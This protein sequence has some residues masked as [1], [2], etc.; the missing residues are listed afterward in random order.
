LCEFEDAHRCS[1]LIWR[2]EVVIA[3]WTCFLSR[4]AV[5]DSIKY[6]LHHDH[7]VTMNI[8]SYKSFPV[9]TEFQGMRITV[10]A[11]FEWI[12]ELAVSGQTG[13][14]LANLLDYVR[15]GAKTQGTDSLTERQIRYSLEKL[16][17]KGFI[18]RS[19]AQEKVRETLYE[20][21]EKAYSLLLDGLRARMQD[22]MS[23]ER[24]R[25]LLLR[26]EVW[27]FATRS[28]IYSNEEWTMDY[29]VLCSDAAS[30]KEQLALS[31]R[32]VLCS[33]CWYP[34]S[35]FK[36]IGVLF[37]DS[38]RVD[39]ASTNQFIDY[40]FLWKDPELLSSL[41][42][43]VCSILDTARNG[44]DLCGM[45]G[46]WISYDGRFNLRQNTIPLATLVAN[47]LSKPLKF[48]DFAATRTRLKELGGR[49]W[50]LI[51]DFLDDISYMR[52]VLDQL[53]KVNALPKIVASAIQSVDTSDLEQ[54]FR[55]S[56]FIA[57]VD[58]SQYRETWDEVFPRVADRL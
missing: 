32:Y 55:K 34:D 16:E 4:S 52:L 11:V 25:D 8:P 17:A 54:D 18:R 56:Q 29:L 42:D 24:L 23:T 3:E 28:S 6:W 53:E 40:D 43:M 10:R 30:A 12:L 44:R 36:R 58:P 26:K 46:P 37:E 49:N 19:T 13:F 14:T 45:L 48:L 20:I 57:F 38:E 41:A 5:R 27:R 51:I 31:R 47:R 9:V 1:C 7:L 21:G 35:W 33:V 39:L 22:P 2:N 50:T 15:G